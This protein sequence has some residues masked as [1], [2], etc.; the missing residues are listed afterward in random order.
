MLVLLYCLSGLAL[1]FVVQGQ[2]LLANDVKKQLRE[3]GQGG[4]GKMGGGGGA[5]NVQRRALEEWIAWLQPDRDYNATLWKQQHGRTSQPGTFFAHYSKELSR[6][7]RSAGGVVNFVMV[8]ACD[9]TH[10][11]TIRERFLADSHWQGVFVEPVALNFKD[12]TNYLHGEKVMDRAHLIKA[13]ATDVCTSATTKIKFPIYESR[14][15]NA[16]HWLRREIGAVLTKDEMSGKKALPKN[17]NSEEVRCVTAKDILTDWTNA[18]RASLQAAS[19]GSLR[20][21]KKGPDAG[22]EMR[23]RPHVVR[24]FTF[25]KAFPFLARRP[26]F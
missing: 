12:L 21:Y 24:L 2:K 14:S 1:L 18:T 19:G 13:A 10:D 17:W 23:R 16:P 3:G 25:K 15:P 26:L 22:K 11:K 7:Y 6:V 4:G 20:K 9:G 8:G 5:A